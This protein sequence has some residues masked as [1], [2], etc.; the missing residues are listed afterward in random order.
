M[1]AQKRKRKQFWQKCL[2]F[3]NVYYPKTHLIKALYSLDSFR[4]CGRL[5]ENPKTGA[6]RDLFLPENDFK[7][8]SQ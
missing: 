6:P 2:T 8:S 5:L 3:L 4:S 1:A 7:T